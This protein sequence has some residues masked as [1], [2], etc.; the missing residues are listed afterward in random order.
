[1]SVLVRA[2]T[3]GGK[4]HGSDERKAVGYYDLVRRYDGDEFELRDE[5]DFSD[6]WMELVGLS[7]APESEPIAAKVAHKAL[8][9]A[10]VQAMKSVTG[11]D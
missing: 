4:V 6:T 7:A 8:G 3:P 11:G 10:H 9:R 1:M 5:K 2:K